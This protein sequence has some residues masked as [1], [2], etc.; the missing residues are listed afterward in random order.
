MDSCTIHRSIF[1][2]PHIDPAFR[3]KRSEGWNAGSETQRQI[4]VKYYRTSGPIWIGLDAQSGA[5]MDS[6]AWSTVG[7]S[8]LEVRTFQPKLT[9]S[10]WHITGFESVYSLTDKPWRIRRLYTRDPCGKPINIL[11][12]RRAHLLVCL[13][14]HIVETASPSS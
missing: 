6:R 11:S 7:E 8:G 1:E 13:C 14:R 9:T 3:L 10:I 5:P 12:H 2:G 4:P